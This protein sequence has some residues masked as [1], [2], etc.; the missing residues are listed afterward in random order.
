[1][2]QMK[3][4]GSHLRSQPPKTGS[5]PKQVRAI[6]CE[7]CDPLD[8]AFSKARFIHFAPGGTGKTFMRLYLNKKDGR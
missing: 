4:Y 3:I 6:S 2:S 5:Q 7:P 8:R 1:M